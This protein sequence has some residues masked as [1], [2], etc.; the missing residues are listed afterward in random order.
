M[1]ASFS[2]STEL[3]ASLAERLVEIIPCAE[4][5]RFGKNGTDA[6]SAAVRLTRAFTGRDRIAVCG[7][8]GWQDW[9]IGSTSRSKGV[10]KSV[11]DLTHTVPYNNL[12]AVDRLMKKHRDE[13][14]ALILEPMNVT[15]PFENYLAEL[16]EL[17]HGHGA[18]LVFDE[19]ITGFRY[20]VG[21][22]QELFDVTPDIASFG[23]AMGNGM[24]ISSIVGRAD[25]MNE[26][27]NVFYS[28]TFGGETLSL[29][30]AIALI[31]KMCR[32]PVIENLWQTGKKLSEAVLVRIAKHGLTEVMTLNGKAP[33]RVMAIADHSEGTK[34]SI[35]TLFMREM[36]NRGVL[37]ASSHN[38]CYAHTDAD[39]CQ[40]LMAYDGALAR[41]AEELAIGKLE[42]RLDTTPIKPIFAV[43]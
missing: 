39:I 6:T 8:H 35:K 33:W 4:M 21:G 42:E 43:R 32:E 23:K 22:A 9:Y 15:E 34:E 12:D 2:L 1:I 36:L 31:D 30:A 17:V 24:P 18:L 10:P 16:K 19:I 11:S 41:V 29:A 13:F 26:M 7:Y 5:V 3:E 40:V 20:A 25:V 28:G 14:A 38:I 37:M 27:E